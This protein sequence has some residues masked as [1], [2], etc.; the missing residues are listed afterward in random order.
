MPNRFMY[1]HPQYKIIHEKSGP[2]VLA[3][4][5][6]YVHF[7]FFQT[8]RIRA[9][10]LTVLT[11]GTATATPADAAL[12][13]S[14]FGSAGTT[15]IANLFYSTHTAGHSLHATVTSTVTPNQGVR[16]AKKLDATGITAPYLEYEV[17]PG[18]L[19]S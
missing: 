3:A 15:S 5:N 8:A 12:E 7:N 18:A 17:L 16:F 10:H 1:D 4:T 11:A 19:Q 6:S 9:V 2:V 14:L 13:V